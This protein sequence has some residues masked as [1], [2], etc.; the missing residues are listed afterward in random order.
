MQQASVTVTSVFRTFQFSNITDVDLNLY[1][2][3]EIDAALYIC[4]QNGVVIQD[5]LHRTYA[6]SNKRYS[7]IANV[8]WKLFKN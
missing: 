7:R 8:R 6:V 1:D 3:T 5:N 2:D 4:L